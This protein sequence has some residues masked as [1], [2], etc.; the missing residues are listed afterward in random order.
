MSRILVSANLI[1][2][3]KIIIFFSA[4]HRYKL[5]LHKDRKAIC[6][7]QHIFACL[8]PLILKVSRNVP[9]SHGKQANIEILCKH[10]TLAE[11]SNSFFSRV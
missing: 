11:N 7:K 10:L 1:V 9:L 4:C 2:D 5:Y 8:P 3:K 6:R